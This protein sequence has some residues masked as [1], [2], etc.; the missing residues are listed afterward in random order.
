MKLNFRGGHF[1]CITVIIRGLNF[2]TAVSAT[3]NLIPRHGYEYAFETNI[4][5]QFFAD[6]SQ[7]RTLRKLVPREKYP[8]SGIP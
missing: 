2:H 4:M 7:S 1:L 8:L 5:G 3:W 6:V